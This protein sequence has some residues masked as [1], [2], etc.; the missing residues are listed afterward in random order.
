MKPR[1]IVLAQIRH[2]TCPEVPYSHSCG[3][4]A[5][6][7]PDLIEIGLDVLESVQPEAADMNP[8]E[9]KRRFGRDICFWGGGCDTRHVLNRASPAEVRRHVLERMTILAPGGGFVFNTVHNILP[10]VPPENVVAMFDAVGEYNRA[11]A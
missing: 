6:I 5:A 11:G 10:D 9:L 8:Y 3:S 4:V 1:D 7:V 2:E